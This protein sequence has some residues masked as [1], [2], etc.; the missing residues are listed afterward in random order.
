MPR[1]PRSLPLIALL[2]AAAPVIPG[3]APVSTARADGDPAKPPAPAPA[4]APAELYEQ[5]DRKKMMSMK[6]PRAWKSVTGE[7]VDPAA[8]CMFKGFIGSET[9]GRPGAAAFFVEN[10]FGRAALARAMDLPKSGT[11]KATSMRQGPGWVEGCAVDVANQAHWR[12]Y[13]EKNGR[14]Y[15]FAIGAA[16]A[17]YDVVHEDV[18]KLLDTATVPGEYVPPASADGLTARK[19]GEFDVMSDADADREK[20]VAKA[21]ATLATARDAVAK[22]VPGKPFDAAHPIAWIYQ[23]G[24]KFEDRGKSATGKPVAN[25]AFDAADHCVMVSILGD[26][27]VGHDDAV[28]KAGAEQYVWQYFGGESPIWV[29]S[30]LAKYGQVVAQGGGKGK[31]LP[32]TLTKTKAAIAAGK[33]RL[34]EWFDVVLAIDVADP[35]QAALE[36]YGWHSYF[37]VG[38][39]AKKFKKQYDSYLQILRDSGDPA[40]ARKAFDGVNFADMLAD[41]KSWAADWK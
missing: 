27:A 32:D 24:Q 21:C 38:K 40:A 39:G 8:L 31:I 14:V 20:S 33:R 11:I 1:L 26:S 37:R 19:S 34:D 10:A 16:A 28:L 2:L 12:R 7:E 22:L 23:N 15:K 30:G 9:S 18:E 13:V 35:D 41:F 29:A 3:M 17:L 25:A 6:I 36:L 4:P 5:T